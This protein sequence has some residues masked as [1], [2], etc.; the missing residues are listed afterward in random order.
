[1]QPIR[2]LTHHFCVLCEHVQGVIYVLMNT[3]SV[4][5]SVGQSS[6]RA[7]LVCKLILTRVT[8]V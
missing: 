2:G 7:Y 3:F 4:Q 1:M 5:F 8:L 6:S